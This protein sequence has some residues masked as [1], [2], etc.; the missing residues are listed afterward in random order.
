[1]PPLALEIAL[2]WDWRSTE[3]RVLFFAASSFG[4][5]ALGFDIRVESGLN[6]SR[7]SFQKA[8]NTLRGVNRSRISFQKAFSTLR[9][10][11]KENAQ[12]GLIKLNP[13]RI[14]THKQEN[15]ET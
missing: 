10:L 8:F 4:F 9:T 2:N 1:M 12:T 3:R 6:G 5:S 7:I 11:P 14:R 15:V 13:F